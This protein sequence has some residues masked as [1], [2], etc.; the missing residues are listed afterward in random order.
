MKKI[1]F[2]LFFATALFGASFS[3]SEYRT[4]LLSVDAGSGNIQD[5]PN[6]MVGSSGIVMRNFGNGL[7]SIIARAV[8]DS[9]S[10]DYAQIHFEVY[11]GLKQSALPLP[12]YTPEPGDEIV[13]NYL[14]DR[15]LIIAPNA[16][17]YNQIVTAFPN[18]TFIHPDL[19]GAQLSIDYKPNPS[20]DDLRRA[21]A[22]NVAGLLFLALEGEAMFMDCGSFVPLKRF[23]SGAVAQYNLPFYTRVRDIKT[24]FWK[25]DSEHINNYDKYYKFIFNLNEDENAK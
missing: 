15:A 5:S 23:K 3:M 17:I 25:L 14:Y 18:I 11:S 22:A 4:G 10:G 1:F 8:V 9:K 24:V 7:K 6:I 12:N 16:D 21:C 2:S 20:Q 19:V 13:L